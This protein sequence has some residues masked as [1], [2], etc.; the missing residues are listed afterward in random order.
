MIGHAR[1]AAVSYAGAA[2]LLCQSSISR[3]KIRY[4]KVAMSSLLE[5]A[6]TDKCRSD[7]PSD[8]FGVFFLQDIFRGVIHSRARGLSVPWTMSWRK[9]C[10]QQTASTLHK[11]WPKWRTRS[12]MTSSPML[13]RANRAERNR[14]LLCT[15]L[16]P[17]K[18]TFQTLC[19]PETVTYVNA[20]VVISNY[21]STFTFDCVT[22]QVWHVECWR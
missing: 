5:M 14:F 8:K 1:S 11:C 3:S 18:Y 10:L 20:D 15:R 19:L 4:Y 22:F 17:R 6:V 7:G 13:R 2:K 16:L 9:P 12:R 21:L